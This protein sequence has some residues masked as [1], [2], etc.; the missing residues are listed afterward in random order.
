M[1]NKKALETT[2]GKSF[3]SLATFAGFSLRNIF[4]NFITTQTH[5]RQRDWKRIKI[6]LNSFNSSNSFHNI[7]F[8]SKPI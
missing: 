2:I 7:Y 6:I 4:Y 8:I 3:S 1:Q 5:Y